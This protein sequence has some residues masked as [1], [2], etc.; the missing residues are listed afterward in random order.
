MN[1]KKWFKMCAQAMDCTVHIYIVHIYTLYIYIDLC[2]WEC[3][4]LTH[5]YGSTWRVKY[6]AV[7]CSV[8]CSCSVLQCVTVYVRCAQIDTK[9][10]CTYIRST[11]CWER[12]RERERERECV[13][14]CVYTRLNTRLYTAPLRESEC[15]SVRVCLCIYISHH[16]PSCAKWVLAHTVT[17]YIIC[18]C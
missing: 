2:V 13:C 10:L 9:T 17:S 7:C 1:K 15:A 6:D 16:V 5:D 14:V 8:C 12:E 3:M 11:R 4:L 18:M